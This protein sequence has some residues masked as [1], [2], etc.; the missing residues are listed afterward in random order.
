MRGGLF[1]GLLCF[2]L[3]LVCL[4]LGVVSLVVR[5]LYCQRVF[6]SGNANEGCG[7]CGFWDVVVVENVSQ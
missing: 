1:G 7:V 5:C 3:F 4:G 6:L 2:W